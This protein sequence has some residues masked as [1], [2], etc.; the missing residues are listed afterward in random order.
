LLAF[1][2]IFL[3]VAMV[4]MPPKMMDLMKMMNSQMMSSGVYE[5][6]NKY[7]GQNIPVMRNVIAV[8]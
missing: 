8:I 1:V 5:C 6:A 3:P 2:I 7:A 4:A